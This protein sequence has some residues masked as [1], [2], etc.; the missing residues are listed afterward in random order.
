[1]SE[2]EIYSTG[3]IETVLNDTK[4]VTVKYDNGEIKGEAK[5]YV[6]R[7]FKMGPKP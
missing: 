5:M 2:V 1:M 7:V 6:D 4:E 3:I